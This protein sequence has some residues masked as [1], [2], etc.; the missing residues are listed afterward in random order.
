MNRG[1]WWATVHGFA[2]SDTTEWLNQKTIKYSSVQLLYQSCPTLCDPMYCSTPGFPPSPTFKSLLKLLSIE[3]VMPSNHLILC[4]PLLLC[5][6]SFPELGSFLVN[7]FFTSGN[8]SIGA[9]ASASVLPMNIQDWFP[10]GST[11][12]ISLQSKGLSWIFSNT[13]VKTHQFFCGQPSLWS[14]FHIHTWLLEKP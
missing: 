13:T 1:T 12:L 4:R 6:Q 2:Q 7:Q 14:N 8:Q 10:L 3:L 5:L 9:S 11:G